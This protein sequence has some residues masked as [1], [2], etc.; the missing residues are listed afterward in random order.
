MKIKIQKE[1]PNSK[2]P[3]RTWAFEIPE[4]WKHKEIVEHAIELA[5]AKP[6]N[7]SPWMCTKS[8]PFPEDQLWFTHY[9]HKIPRTILIS[10]MAP[11]RTEEEIKEATAKWFRSLTRLGAKEDNEHN[12][13]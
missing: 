12:D 5:R 8:G 10:I 6:F 7:K 1:S 3:L 2:N 9:G 4:T 13:S 11:E